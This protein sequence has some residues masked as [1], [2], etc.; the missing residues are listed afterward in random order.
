MREAT[1]LHMDPTLEHGD[2]APRK[3]TV[4]TRAHRVKRALMGREYGEGSPRDGLARLHEELHG[5]EN[6]D[7]KFI[8]EMN[9]FGD[10]SVI[11]GFV[12]EL[13]AWGKVFEPVGEVS[14][15]AVLYI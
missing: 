6:S 12:N 8:F 15:Y 2:R 5:R 9:E 13:K 7:G 4:R 1:M 14:M 11:M 10:C 3:T